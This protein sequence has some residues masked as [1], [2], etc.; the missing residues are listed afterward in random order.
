MT[1]PV[2]NLRMRP[3]IQSIWQEYRARVN[4]VQVAKEL[5][6]FHFAPNERGQLGHNFESAYD[7]YRTVGMWQKVRG[8]SVERAV[9]D[10]ARVLSF[11]K[12]AVYD[13]LV[14]G[15]DESADPEQAKIDS[16]VKTGGLVLVETPRAAY[17]NYELID[18]N[19]YRIPRM[20]EYLWR[21]AEHGHRGEAILREQ[22]GDSGDV[23][24]LTK[25][26][27]RLKGKKAFPGSLIKKIECR[28]TGTQILDLQ[29]DLIWLISS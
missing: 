22:F 23:K 28:G 10:V 8:G 9:L 16:A 13:W 4:S 1:A 3:E 12:P 21:L 26:K 27:S 5:W 11:I 29:P 18:L 25:L 2:P 19:W 6:K 14:D 24:F 7:Q 17:W 20:W 15:L